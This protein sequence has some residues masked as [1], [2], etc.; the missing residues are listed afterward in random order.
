M[1]HCQDREQAV[2]WCTTR[3]EWDN[4]VLNYRLW[5][6]GHGVSRGIISV[7]KDILI[8]GLHI[9]TLCEVTFMT[10]DNGTKPT[11]G[12]VTFKSIGQIYDTED[13]SPEENRDLSERAEE[14]IFHTVLNVPKGVRAA[15][16]DDLVIRVPVQ[17]LT[18][19]RSNAIISAVRSH[20]RRRADEMQGAMKITQ[21]VG[22][23]QIRLTIAVCIPAFI[24]IAICS[25]FK[26][27]PLAEVIENVLVILAWVTIWQP[28]QVL[29]FDRWTAKETAKVY[30]KIAEMPINVSS[31]A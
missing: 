27:N 19:E 24:G 5:A 31:S 29:V 12:T 2:A 9:Q 30:R 16:C 15:V 10:T 11:I 28:F 26:G 20:F 3:R 6:C 23:R 13:P 1:F 25:Q 8:T 18:Q 22:L 14:R 4:K 21:R 7:K 17:E